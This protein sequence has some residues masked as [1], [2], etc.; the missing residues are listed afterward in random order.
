[1]VDL[2]PSV[3]ESF[4]GGVLPPR[5][6]PWPEASFGPEG[7]IRGPWVAPAVRGR[8]YTVATAGQVVELRTRFFGESAPGGGARGCVHGFSDKSRR[9]LFR[10]CSA[11]PWEVFGQSLFVTLTY[12]KRFPVDGR[13]VKRNLHAFRSAWVRQYGSVQAVWKLEFQRRGAPHFHLAVVMN[14][15]VAE[16]RRWVSQTWF[17]IV[18]SGDARHLR[19]GTQVQ[20]ARSN[21]AAYFAGYV[22]SH[23]KSK[24]YQHRV[25][26]GF[27]E[28]GRFWGLWGM[29]PQWSVELVGAREWI[30]LRRM[31]YSLGR[32][33]AR[34]EGRCVRRRRGR[35]QGE[36]H[37][38]DGVSAT[39]LIAQLRRAPGVAVL[40]S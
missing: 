33:K 6:A 28:V 40:R 19:A 10:T 27:E 12:P 34:A 4:A 1:M 30:E 2:L 14:G 38:Y 11:L 8:S 21:L 29:R 39:L 3:A 17:R 37:R 31:L 32:S 20:V 23:A 13:Q 26:E 7:L 24:A 22:G 9:R 15:D 16:C 25:P 35:V 36:W 5:G 18:S